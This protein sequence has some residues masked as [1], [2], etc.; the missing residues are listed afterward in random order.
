[1]RLLI[2]ILTALIT[3]TLGLARV[4]AFDKP[5]LDGP[6]TPRF[7][8]TTIEAKFRSEGIAVADVNKDG[9]PDLMIGD[10]WYE[11]PAWTR[12][13]IRPPGDF[14]DGLRS[15]SRCMTCWTDDVDGDGWADQIVIGFP[16]TECFWYRNPQGASGH[17]KQFVAWPSACNETPLYTDLF[18]DG[19]RVLVMAWQPKGKNDQGTMAW[20]QPAA[21]PTQPWTMNPI[22]ETAAA[23]KPVPGTQQFSH[24]LGAGDLNGDGRLDVISVGGWWEQPAEGRNAKG[25]WKFHPARLGDAVADMITYDVDGDGKADVIDSSAH[26]FGIWWFR[27]GESKDGSPV[28]TKNDLFPELVSETH[29]LIAADINGDGLRDFVTG[30]RFWSHGKAEPGS[31][32]PAKLYWFE[33]SKDERNMTKFTP[34]EID[35]QSGIGTQFVVLDFNGDGLLD[36]ATANKKGVF[37]FEQSR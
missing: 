23:D 22:S 29:A 15:Y 4:E 24:G 26:R 14:G 12:H 32:K 36:I 20:F 28:F 21:D 33:A 25:P 11:A 3:S 18:G 31:D 35:D 27:Q 8:K 30:K 5:T 9:K 10:F 17:W 7:K 16:G 13:E 1:M 6:A 34:R 2:P 19:K 37:L